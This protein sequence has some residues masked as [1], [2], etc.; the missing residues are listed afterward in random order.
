MRPAWGPLKRNR[1]HHPISSSCPITCLPYRHTRGP[2]K[3]WA[4]GPDRL[5][6]MKKALR[7][8]G[9]WKLQAEQ[10]KQNDPLDKF[11]CMCSSRIWFR[12]EKKMQL[13]RV[14][15]LRARTRVETAAHARRAGKTTFFRHHAIT[16]R[17]G[18]GILA[19]AASLDDRRT[20]ARRSISHTSPAAR[21]RAGGCGAGSLAA[22]DGV[23][24]FRLYA[25]P[26]TVHASALRT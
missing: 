22:A 8:L 10:N 21:A 1:P 23:V 4:H 16:A 19:A 12:S 14:P 18:A 17:T 15:G 11:Q 20:R 3:S 13:G 6:L 26:F 2:S 7:P 25:S 24:L 9:P 5:G